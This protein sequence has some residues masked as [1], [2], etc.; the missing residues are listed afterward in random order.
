MAKC[1]FLSLL[2]VL[3]ISCQTNLKTTSSDERFFQS[4]EGSSGEE[5]DDFLAFTIDRSHRY[6]LPK[7][8]IK[9]KTYRCSYFFIKN[10]NAK[11]DYFSAI[12]P[13]VG[14][15]TDDPHDLSLVN[16]L[17]FKI[18]KQ[19]PSSDQKELMVLEI[20]TK[21]LAYRQ[22][23]VGN[24]VFVPG[25]DNTVLT[26]RVTKVFDLG[27]GMP[28][29]ALLPESKT[30]TPLLIFRGTNLNNSSS[31]FADLDLD[32]PGFSAFMNHRDL[33]RD[34]AVETSKN[35]PKPRVMGYSLGGSFTQYMYIYESEVISS[36]PKSYHVMFNQPGVS[37]E[38]LDKWDNMSP[39]KYKML[40]GYV[41]EG[42]LVSSVGHLIGSVHEMSLD[43]LLEPI[44]AHVTFMTAQ[45][46][47][48]SYPLDLTI[49]IDKD[50]SHKGS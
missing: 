48:Y 43:T 26:Y 34:W 7:Y 25:K 3:V 23:E 49:K 17:L 39:T 12:K 50:I 11:H 21:I 9:M 31:V 32:G 5:F 1:F 38:L 19:I 24:V 18:A 37:H 14:I 22:L 20:L 8:P 35:Y 36:D 2:S 42:D 40:K 29:F 6:Y 30:D 47:L 45:P 16:Q 46:N 27:G 28:A 10:F 44:A 4:E 33:L 41:N 15:V 13:L